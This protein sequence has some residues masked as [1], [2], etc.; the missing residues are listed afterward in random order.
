MGVFS[1]E[2][3]GSRPEQVKPVDDDDSVLVTNSTENVIDW[4]RLNKYERMINVVVYCFRFRSKQRGIVTA[5][6]R[7]KSALLILQMT[8]RESFA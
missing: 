7:Q 4:S 3:L 2:D 6:K 1:A 8:Q 5:L